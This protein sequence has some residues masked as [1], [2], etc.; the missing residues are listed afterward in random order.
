[1]YAAIVIPNF[2]LQAILRLHEEWRARPFAVL[3][4]EN[5]VLQMTAAAREQYVEAGMT[6]TQAMARY[7]KIVL[8]ARSL[9]QEEAAQKA[10]IQCAAGFSPFLESTAPGICTIN[11][12]GLSEFG[13]LP[14]ELS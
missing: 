12:R 13:A 5:R 6:P 10:L 2:S 8:R 14:L 1:M 3:D 11:L 7:A 9:L 4:E